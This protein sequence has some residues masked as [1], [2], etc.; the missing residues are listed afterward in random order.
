MFT[1]TSTNLWRDTRGAVLI[2]VTVGMTLLLGGAALVID[3][4]RLYTM[5]SELQAAADSFAPACAAELDRKADSHTRATSAVIGATALVANKDTYSTTATSGILAQAPIFLSVLPAGS[6]ALSTA[7]VSTDPTETRFC[8]VSVVAKTMDTYFIRALTG[9][10]SK[11][12]NAV[13]VAGFDL[14]V[15]EFTPLFICNPYEFGSEFASIE[16]AVADAGFRRRL[17]KLAALGGS[18]QASAGNFGFLESPMGPGAAQLADSLAVGTPNTCFIENGVDTKTGANTGP[19]RT[20]LNVRFDMYRGSFNGKKN[21]GAYRPG[22]NVRKGWAG[23]PDCMGPNDS[24]TNTPG[25]QMG[26]PRD[27]CFDPTDAAFPCTNLAASEARMGT[28]MWDFQ[29][30]WTTNHAAAAPF[31][32]SD[33]DPPSRYEVY[34]EEIDSLT[35]AEAAPSGETG[36]SKCYNGSVAPDDDPDRRLLYAAVI[37]CAANLAPGA[38]SG[39]PVE[40]WLKMFITEP[41]NSVDG[42]P[43]NTTDAIYIEIVDILEAGEDDQVLRDIVQ[44]YR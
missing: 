30:Y 32:W 8:Q 43:A 12:T 23:T 33:A 10:T 26:L 31:G 25:T 9:Q 6:A 19:V 40:A 44:L 13:A 3:A 34:R 24:V 28:G 18:D 11:T 22:L 37:D 27:D 36:M 1:R 14:A 2:Y 35:Y 5:N 20:A 21:N 7:T 4:G 39:V 29:D 16:A 42:D 38:N 15:C 41:V 17:F